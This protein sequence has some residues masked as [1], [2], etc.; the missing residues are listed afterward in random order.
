MREQLNGLKCL[1]DAGGPARRDGQP[2][3]QGPPG[4]VNSAQ[5]TQAINGTSSNS[6]GLTTL[7]NPFADPDAEALRQKFNELLMALR[8]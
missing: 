4:D 5:L 1:I 3:P 8:R 6:N 2:G 7:D